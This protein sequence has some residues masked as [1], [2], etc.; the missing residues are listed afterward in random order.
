M[1]EASGS[2]R[3][4]AIRSRRSTGTCSQA[5][6][7][8]RRRALSLTERRTCH[9]S[10]SIGNCSGVA[11]ISTPRSARIGGVG[12]A[13]RRMLE[14]AP[15]RHR[16]RA[17]L[18]RAV[19]LDEE[20]R[21]A[22]GRVVARLRLALEEDDLA[23]RRQRVADRGGGDAGADDEEIRTG[24]AGHRGILRH[25]LQ[26]CRA[27]PG[28]RALC[29][30]GSG[31]RPASERLRRSLLPSASVLRPSRRPLRRSSRPGGPA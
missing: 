31:N 3:A 25:A 4:P 21:R 22:P 11:T 18:R 1:S 27:G 5:C 12:E 23:A 20:R 15:A 26:R 28:Q 8:S 6:A 14:E 17:H 16:Q 13:G 9:C 10:S 29:I 2:S 19:A 7:T 24:I 30:S